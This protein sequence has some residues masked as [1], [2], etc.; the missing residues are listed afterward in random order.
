MARHKK[1][2]VTDPRN[3]HK[4]EIPK[5]ELDPMYN[6]GYTNKTRLTKDWMIWQCTP[7]SANLLF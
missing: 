3:G 4:K 7:K 6:Q 5:K 2:A 1:Q